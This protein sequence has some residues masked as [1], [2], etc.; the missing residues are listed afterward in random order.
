MKIIKLL[1]PPIIGLI[2]TSFIC[3]NYT[4]TSLFLIFFLAGSLLKKDM[5]T[6]IKRDPEDTSSEVFQFC[7]FWS[8]LSLCG[9]LL[10]SSIIN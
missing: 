8:A 3:D 4:S 9:A 7:I 5:F 6:L 2:L 1:S 10:A